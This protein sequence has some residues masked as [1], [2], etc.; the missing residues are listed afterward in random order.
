[1]TTSKDWVFGRYRLRNKSF[2][3]Y[4]NEHISSIIELI[5]RSA[6]L[7]G[8]SIAI[9]YMVKKE[10]YCKTYTELL[11]DSKKT[12]KYF[13][14]LSSNRKHVAVLG[15]SS[16]EWIVAYLGTIFA[17]NVVV[18]LDK[19]LSTEDLIKLVKQADVAFLFYGSGYEKC[20]EKIHSTLNIDIMPLNKLYSIA[21]TETALPIVNPDKMQTVLFTSGTTGES[22][23][24]MLSQRN[25]A[26]NVIQG[27]GAVDL[28]HDRDTIM[29]VLPLNHA[30]EFT[31]TIL[32]MIY[33]GVPICISSGLKRL[34]KELREFQPTVI[35]VVPIFAETL[36]K[37]VELNIQKQNKEKTFNLAVKVNRLFNKIHIDL[38]DKLFSGI[39]AAFGG[40]LKIIMCGGAPLTEDLISKYKDIGINLFQGYGL[41][42][43]SPLLTVNF[44]Y[45]H[46]PNSVGKV[47]DGNEV[48][49]VDGEIWARGVSVSKGYYNNPIETEKSFENGWFKT[50]DLG[51]IDEDEFVFLNGR[52]KN[53][54]ILNTGENI[55]AEELELMLQKIADVNEVIVY[56]EN[57]RIVAEIFSERKCYDSIKAAVATLNTGLPSYKN[58]DNVKFRSTPFEKTTTNKIRR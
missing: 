5:E 55:S 56:A 52:K 49:I 51:W 46:R 42:E 32:G 10:M 18:P 34:Q 37:K 4:K 14:E 40:K 47:V 19:E 21:D 12:A 9:K 41:T 1:M 48:K 33:K 25:I 22:K 58:I 20:A 26:S 57:N 43:C 53:L 35:F 50:G 24:V 16:Y 39:K 30:Y 27:L 29:S 17:G 8:D 6:S 44:D 28:R 31:C 3:F 11:N 7:Y 54:I 15:A 2:E 38:S 13:C 36:Y 23:G 45:Y